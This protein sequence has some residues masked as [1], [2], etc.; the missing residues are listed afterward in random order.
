MKRTQIFKVS[1][2]PEREDRQ[3]FRVRDVTEVT[4]QDREHD[5]VLVAAVQQRE[6]R[7]VQSAES[8]LRRLV[9]PLERVRRE[10]VS[11]E[12]KETTCASDC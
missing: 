3:T 9:N 7:R 1:R 10:T 4:E 8:R 6:E 5:S 12:G 11:K 2:D